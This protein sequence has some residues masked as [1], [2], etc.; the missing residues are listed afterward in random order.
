VVVKPNYTGHRKDIATLD[1]YWLLWKS[2]DKFPRRILEL[3]VD[4]GGSL[5]LWNDLFAPMYVIGLDINMDHEGLSRL[6]EFHSI[7][8]YPF[9]QRDPGTLS[10]V[11]NNK[12]LLYASFDLIIDDCSHD[13]AG[14]FECMRILWD[15]LNPGGAYVIED[16]KAYDHE[17]S[18]IKLHMCLNTLDSAH[19]LTSAVVITHALVGLVKRGNVVED[20]T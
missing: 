5:L 11:F 15:R 17:Q 1:S 4:S 12:K 6:D 18:E 10:T 9:D 20:H 16:W 14:A 2:M 7:N 13:I 3:G 19:M 8:V